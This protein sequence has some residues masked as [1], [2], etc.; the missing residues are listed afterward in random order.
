[1]PIHFDLEA[2]C[3]LAPSSSSVDAGRW[4]E[5]VRAARFDLP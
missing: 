1:M 4:P 2:R 3:R 5:L